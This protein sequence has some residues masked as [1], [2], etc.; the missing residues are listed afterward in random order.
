MESYKESFINENFPD[1]QFIHDN[2]SR[3]TYELSSGSYFKK[4]PFPNKLNS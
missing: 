1:I 2:E 3:S 4:P